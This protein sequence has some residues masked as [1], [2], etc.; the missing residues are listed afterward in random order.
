LIRLRLAWMRSEVRKQL[1]PESR[2]R[3]SCA[4]AHEKSKQAAQHAGAACDLI[5]V[6]RSQYQDTVD[7]G[8][9]ELDVIAVLRGIEA[10]AGAQ[11]TVATERGMQS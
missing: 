4:A 10:H 2:S 9:G 11:T 8:D 6:C 5:Q 1:R 3:G 7:L